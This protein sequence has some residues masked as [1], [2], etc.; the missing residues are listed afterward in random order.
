MDRAGN[1]RAQAVCAQALKQRAACN[2]AR[3]EGQGGFR[4][5][6]DDEQARCLAELC[7]AQ[8]LLTGTL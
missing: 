8:R 5:W 7:A 2:I 4:A 1:I 3:I 6:K